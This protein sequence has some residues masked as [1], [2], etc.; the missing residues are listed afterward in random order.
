MWY[1][2]Y[3][4]NPCPYYD[5]TFTELISI[6]KDTTVNN[7]TYKK[8]F[9]QYGSEAPTN[10]KIYGL[11][12]ETEDKKVYFLQYDEETLYYD[13]NLSIMDTIGNWQLNMIEDIFVLGT[14]RKKYQ[15]ISICTYDTTY[16]IEGIGNINGPFYS[17]N[18]G[19]IGE[20]A[21]HTSGGSIYELNCVIENNNKIYESGLY[22][23]CWIFDPW[24]E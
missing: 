3:H 24:I 23:D 6:G 10:K 4:L 7:M 22:D 18:F 20:L 8:V 21:W 11:A 14:E 12:R 17:D 9:I 15:F 2:T 5:C 13:F 19:C 16:W 1:V